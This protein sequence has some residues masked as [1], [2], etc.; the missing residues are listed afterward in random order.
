MENHTFVIPAYKDSPYIEECIISLTTQK[1]KSQIIIVTSTPSEYIQKIAQKYS[2]DVIVNHNANKGIAEDWNFAL[3]QPNTP[4]VTIAHQD[5]IYECEYL[6]KVLQLL[7]HKKTLLV[8]TDYYEWVD[9]K[10]RQRSLNLSIKKILLFPFL[11]KSSINNQFFKRLPLLF[12]NPICCPSVTY[13][14][15]ELHGFTFSTKYNYNVDWC[16]WLELSR[17][18]GAFGFINKKLMKH[19]L[20][21]DSETSIQIKSNSRKQEEQ[22]ILEMIWGKY[23]GGFISYIYL[24]GHKDNIIQQ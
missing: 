10:A 8:F 21:R 3:S 7:K 4:L 9:G 12:G 20:H 11:F 24:W 18:D 19:R 1:I 17:K 13:N 2:I 14:R 5:D 6:E 22:K 23:I 15:D 16:A